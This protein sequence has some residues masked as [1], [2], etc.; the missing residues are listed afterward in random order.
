MNI[1]QVIENLRK[2]KREVTPNI[3]KIIEKYIRDKNLIVYGGFAIDILLRNKTGKG[4]YSADDPYDY[5]VYS[6][7]FDGDAQELAGILKL[8][9][10]SWIRIVTGINGKTRKIFI[11]LIKESI[12]DF[13]DHEE[14]VSLPNKVDGYRI[15]DPQYMKID[16]YKNIHDN[17][18]SFY[19]RIPKALKKIA[20]LEKYFPCNKKTY[21]ITK[22]K[23]EIKTG[24]DKVF[25]IEGATSSD[26]G[27]VLLCLEKL[28][29]YEVLGGDLIY[30]YYSSGKLIGIPYVYDDYE[31]DMFYDI[32]V[33][34]GKQIKIAT[35][36]SLIYTYYLEKKYGEH[37][38][39]LLSDVGSN[40][41]NIVKT[42]KITKKEIIKTMPTIFLK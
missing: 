2:L 11:N 25:K 16:Q 15:A 29:D 12:I 18:F 23:V 5:D 1:P 17:L 19:H 8:N 6:K 34:E 13:S 21:T 28:K 27:T 41:Y 10:C 20:Q 14:D 38:N 31:D 37:I 26:I 22:N 39:D 30:N 9:G 3:R 36:F 33:Y 35:R 42:P 40:Y 4:L 24:M 7:N 32:L